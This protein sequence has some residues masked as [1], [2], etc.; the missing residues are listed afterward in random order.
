MAQ[1]STVLLLQLRV[2]HTFAKEKITPFNNE[3]TLGILVLT[4]RY[5]YWQTELL[6]LVKLPVPVV[7]VA[8]FASK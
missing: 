7:S 3:V 5:V 1:S 6:T 4:F 2:N 8:P